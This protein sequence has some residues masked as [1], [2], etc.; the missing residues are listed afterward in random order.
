MNNDQLGSWEENATNWSEAIDEG[1]DVINDSF[2]MP[3]FVA[4][5]P[6]LAGLHVLDLGCGEGRSSR[7]IAKAKG[8]KIIGVDISKEMIHL[9]RGKELKLPL[10]ITYMQASCSHMPSIPNGSIDIVTSFMS[11][12]DTANLGL[13]FQEARRV[14]RPGGEIFVM[15]RHPCFFTKGFAVL[16]ART[17]EPI[18]VKVSNYFESSAYADALSFAPGE[19]NPIQIVRF[20]YT[21]SD[22]VE[23]LMTND[24]ELSE[25]SE[26]Q[27]SNLAVIKY[28]IL[29]KWGVHAGL[30]LFLKA[31]K[32]SSHQGDSLP[33]A[34]HVLHS[35]QSRD[36]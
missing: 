24:L 4:K 30:Y 17:G 14:L 31:R 20:G 15:I 28:P 29:K 6:A 35:E 13:A 7:A 25:L 10:G 5:L 34:R 33:K 8:G 2:G 11:L 26:P 32:N 21:L 27:P 22:Y 1:R 16:R 3:F 12:M 23:Q 19:A 18:G 9:A 36:A